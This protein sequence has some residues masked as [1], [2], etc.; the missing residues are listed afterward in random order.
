MKKWIA[1]FLIVSVLFIGNRVYAEEYYT[2]HRGV[3][4]TKQQYDFYTDLMH[5]GFQESITQEA[6][7]EI[8]WNDLDS[9]TIQKTSL[10]PMPTTERVPLLRDDNPIVTTS[11]KS[12]VMVNVCGNTFCSI[13]SNVEWYGIP[14]QQS[15]DVIGAYLDGPELETDPLI[16][17]TTYDDFDDLLT[18]LSG[19]M[20]D[21]A[22][23]YLGADWGDIYDERFECE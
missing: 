5:E 19:F 20:E 6:L 4:F 21:S 17:V 18:C 16:L 15:Y 3:S 12:L 8:D 1:I 14:N 22:E 9:L 7:D 13:L 10:C 23:K 2:N 11:A